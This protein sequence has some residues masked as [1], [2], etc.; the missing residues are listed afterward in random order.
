MLL[1]PGEIGRRRG[2]GH[3]VVD[4]DLVY[5]RACELGV[6]GPNREAVESSP[7]FEVFRA[8]KLEVLFMFDPW[9]EF[10]MEHLQEADGKPLRSGEKAELDIADQAKKEGAL[11]DDEAAAL[12]KWITA[13]DNPYFAK[14]IVNRLWGLFLGKGFVEPI[15][16]FRPSNPPTLPAALDTLAADFTAHD[17][18][19]HHLIRTICASRPYQLACQAGRDAEGGHS[20][21][22]RYPMKQL[23]VEVLLEAALQGL[24][25]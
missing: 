19:L 14:A 9:D 18:D 21:W 24:L 12:A 3:L 23:E 5:H 7:Y 22:S 10:V 8:R 16:D 17:F 20:L 25:A 2:V 1:D 4:L 13:K 15:D 6:L 11:T